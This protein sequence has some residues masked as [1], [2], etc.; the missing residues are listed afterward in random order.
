MRG[1]RAAILAGTYGRYRDA[2][3]AGAAPWDG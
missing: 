2:I 3:L 1:A